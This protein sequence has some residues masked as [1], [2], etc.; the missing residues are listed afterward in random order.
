MPHPIQISYPYIFLVILWFH[1]LKQS[2]PPL[3]LHLKVFLQL[4]TQPNLLTTA[5][6]IYEQVNGNVKPL[7]ASLKKALAEKIVT[8]NDYSLIKGNVTVNNFKLSDVIKLTHPK[9]IS[10]DQ[11]ILFKQIL[12][13]DTPKLDNYNDNI[14][15]A[16]LT[17]HNY[18]IGTNV[19]FDVIYKEWFDEAYL[20][21]CLYNLYE[22]LFKNIISLYNKKLFLNCY[23]KATIKLS[24]K[25]NS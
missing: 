23:F 16:S 19:P 15:R 14:K 2:L 6:S 13:G 5:L 10:K 20:V 11:E 8:F 25:R 1:L 22:K 3:Y 7:A 24:K 17:L 12:D 9:A 4:L 21:I 18:S